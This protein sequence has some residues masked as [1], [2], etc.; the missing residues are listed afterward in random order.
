VLRD[1]DHQAATHE[2]VDDDQQAKL[3]FTLGP[4][5]SNL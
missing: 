3:S 4:E 2:L 1:D 5:N